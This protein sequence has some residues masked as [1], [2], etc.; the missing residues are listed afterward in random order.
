M[1]SMR[2]N[3]NTTAMIT[4]NALSRNDSLLSESTRRL[5][6]GLKINEAKDNP[7]GLAMA[8]R[9]NLQLKG[10]NVANLN[11]EEGVSI[12]RTADGALTEITEM[13]QRMNEL[14]VKGANGTLSD[15]DRRTLD[16]ELIQ[17]KEEITRIASETQFNG[18]SI[19]DGSFDY[20]G[21]S[22][23]AEIKV[24]TFS[25][26]VLAG[27]YSFENLEVTLDDE[28]NIDTYEA[29]ALTITQALEGNENPQQ[30]ALS[31][32]E[33]KDNLMTFEGADGYQIQ[34]KI[35]ESLQAT[36]TFALNLTNMGAMRMQVG[37]N[38]GQVMAL[39][40]PSVD[41]DNLGITKLVLSTE[42][43]CNEAVNT[44][45][46]ALAY[47]SSVRSRLGA[48][49]N[50]LEHKINSLDVTYENMTAAYSQIMDV[51]MA[52]EM[53]YYSTQQVLS[54]ASMAM[55]AQANERPTQVLQL[56]Q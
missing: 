30:I 16:D 34:I 29:Q 51:D 18:Q 50:R 47:I 49:E 22:D 13:V 32:T 7:S 14:A 9:M 4:N 27:T 44:I 38:E 11:A 56:L 35:T 45:S 21:Y 3:Y 39:R 53:T 25:D 54:Q 6:S 5:S 1:G 46:D 33:V 10:V 41:L 20:K 23:K 40:I 52:E 26:N 48:Y 15:E 42:E 2:I 36:D 19:L 17:L 55:L 8:K 24:I 12:V 37:A 43:D 31:V 28:G